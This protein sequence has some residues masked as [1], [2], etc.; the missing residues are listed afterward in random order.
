MTNILSVLFY[1]LKKSK[2]FWVMLGV[3]AVLP[4]LSVLLLVTLGAFVSPFFDEA[5]VGF[6]EILHE[7]NITT[8]ELSSY[9]DLM[10]ISSLLAIITS[11]VFLSK[12]FSYG[13][14]R[15]V[16][17]ANRSRLELYASHLIVSMV[18]G[19]GFL[20]ASMTTTLVASGAAFGFGQM[21]A[22]EC[23]G[24]VV[25]AFAMGLVSVAFAQVLMCMLL[26]CTRRLAVALA[27]SIVICMVAPGLIATFVELMGVFSLLSAGEVNIDS[28]WTPLYNASLLDVADLNGALVG[29]ILLYLVPLTVFFGFMGWVGFRKA[30]LK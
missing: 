19:A 28:T 3:T 2:L 12:E 1:R 6:W 20:G 15:N 5:E 8:S 14:Y 27:C 26:F 17:L 4:I 23:V 21:P 30:D 18:I 24:A 9:G 7:L 11:S 10:H 29:K 16:L 25:T 13:T 22:L